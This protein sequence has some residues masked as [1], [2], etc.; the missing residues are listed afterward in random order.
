M[1]STY[2]EL[3][4]TALSGER[5]DE[6]EDWYRKALAIFEELGDRLHAAASYHQLGIIAQR[7]ERV[8][9][10]ENGTGKPSPSERTLAT[11]REWR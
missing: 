10:A 1:A 4:M 8:D 11:G 3:G 7:R 5:V 6:A 2:H 9:E